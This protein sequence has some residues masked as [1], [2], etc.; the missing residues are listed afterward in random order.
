MAT[1]ALVEVPDLASEYV[2]K[3]LDATA[4]ISEADFEA[5]SQR[6]EAVAKKANQS[7]VNSIPET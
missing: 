6:I 1:W 4:K 3:I 7:V 2:G 5:Q